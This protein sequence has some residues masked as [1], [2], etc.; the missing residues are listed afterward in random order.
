[1]ATATKS[2][3]NIKP[4]DDRIIV[5]PATSDD[6]TSAGII[7]PESAQEKP[8]YGTVIAVGPGKLNDDDERTPLSVTIGD[9]VVYGKYSATE[10]EWDGETLLLLRESDLLAKLN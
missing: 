10:I 5:R 9:E 1:M 8:Q 4:L 2:K 7:L 6:T 3:V